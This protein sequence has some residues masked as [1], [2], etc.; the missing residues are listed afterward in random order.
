MMGAP[1]SSTGTTDFPFPKDDISTGTVGARG[2][3]K[4][5]FQKFNTF[6]AWPQSFLELLTD[7]DGKPI[8]PDVKA[9]YQNPGY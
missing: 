5:L 9:A 1:S 2:V 3:G 6:K 4:G 8:T 7:K